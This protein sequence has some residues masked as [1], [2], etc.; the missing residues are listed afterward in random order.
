MKSVLKSLGFDTKVLFQSLASVCDDYFYVLDFETNV[1]LLSPNAVRDFGIVGDGKHQLM[2]MWSERIHPH[3]RESVKKT[4][5]EFFSSNDTELAAEYQI[6]TATGTYIWVS[7]KSQIHR[8]ADSGKPAFVWGAM[9]NLQGYEGVDSVTGLLRCSFGK[10]K[11]ENSRK[12]GRDFHAEIMLLGID[13]FN[14]IN[15]LND[16]RFGDVVLQ[17]IAQDVQKML[18]DRAYLYRYEGD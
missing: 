1:F 6:L 8:D 16:H 11:F 18:P 17:T 2:D 3:S 12:S 14:V 13:E 10:E 4:F 7:V 15:I 9:R 5:T